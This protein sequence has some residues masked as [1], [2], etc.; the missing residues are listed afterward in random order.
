VKR[1][2]ALFFLIIVACGKRGD[3]RPPVPLIPQATSDLVVTQ[4]ANRIVLTWSYPALTT[5]G[6]NLP[7]IRRIVVYRH[8]DQLP[9]SAATSPA[10]PPEP[11][12][13]DPVTRFATVPALAPAQFARLATRI[14]SIEGA[15]LASATVGS[16]LAF[17]D[18]P[19]FRSI[20]GGPI[21]LTY[22]VVTEGVS[23]RSELSNLVLIVPLDVAVAPPSLTAS[24]KPTGV[25]LAWPAPK[26]AAT[27]PDITP[28]IVGYNIYRDAGDELTTPINPSPVMGTT[29]SDTPPYGDHTYRVTAV[30]SA[31]P[32]RIESE[33]SPAASVTFKDLLPPPTPAGLL[34]LVETSRVRLIWD[35]VEVPDLAGYKVYR[36]EGTG[37]TELKEVGG[38]AIIAEPQPGT[39]FLDAGVEKG[40]SYRYEVTAVDKSGNES[41]P[42]KTGW[43]LVPKTP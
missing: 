37:I 43:V 5:A 11:S 22:G 20:S 42:A 19:P 23:A 13:P 9:P 1:L 17:E 10:A 32:P 31:G 41:A 40:I 39:N 24:T 25:T 21:R 18:S 38:F 8:I 15:N 2:G 7:S 28:V 12:I 29:F 6:R 36:Y 35:P 33:P 27:G 34:A 26:A 3:P 30:A 16:R 14:D 4:R